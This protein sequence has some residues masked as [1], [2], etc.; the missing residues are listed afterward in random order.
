MT[1]LPPEAGLKDVVNLLAEV[2]EYHDMQIRLGE[3]SVL[4]RLNK[5]SKGQRDSQSYKGVRFP[6]STSLV[7]T[8]ADKV[9]ILLQASLDPEAK[10]PLNP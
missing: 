2:S 5:V 3:K 6:I 9:K 1:K 10:V 4:N 8:S 7:T